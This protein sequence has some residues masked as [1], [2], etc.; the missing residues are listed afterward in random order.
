MPKLTNNFLESQKFFV[1]NTVIPLIEANR[2]LPRDIRKTE[3]R[4]VAEIAFR[5]GKS[6]KQI[7]KLMDNT[8]KKPENSSKVI[9]S[10]QLNLFYPTA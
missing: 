1:Q 2:K 7:L 8:E 10:E 5:Y 9:Q 6:A 4:M 3:S